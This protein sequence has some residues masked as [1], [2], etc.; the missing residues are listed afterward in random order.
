MSIIT[1]TLKNEVL[2]IIGRS[3]T[4]PFSLPG[5]TYSLVPEAFG[6][7][8]SSRS[9]VHRPLTIENIKTFKIILKDLD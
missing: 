5:V 9:L 1:E 7:P 8:I 2:T 3:V 4:P 6:R